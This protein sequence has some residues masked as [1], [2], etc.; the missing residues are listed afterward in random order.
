MEHNEK[1]PSNRSLKAR[2]A[3]RAAARKAVRVYFYPASFFFNVLKSQ[4]KAHWMRTYMIVAVASAVFIVLSIVSL[5]P[6]VDRTIN[7]YALFV[8]TAFLVSEYIGFLRMIHSETM[9][10]FDQASCTLRLTILRIAKS[11]RQIS[12]MV[13]ALNIIFLLVQFEVTLAPLQTGIFS[14]MTINA[15]YLTDIRIDHEKE[16]AAA[17]DGLSQLKSLPKFYQTFALRTILQHMKV[18]V[19]SQLKIAR[20]IDLSDVMKTLYLQYVL[21]DQPSDKI[22]DFTDKLKQSLSKKTGDIV[23]LLNKTFV[24]EDVVDEASPLYFELPW[25]RRFEWGQGLQWGFAI[26]DAIS[27]IYLLRSFGVFDALYKYFAHT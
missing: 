10:V 17:F 7:P 24:D 15:L 18:R 12:L 9:K 5:K 8:V 11:R 14:Y 26:L 22:R 20:E 1:K 27:A 21:R 19:E 3:V 23:G 16:M 2:E 25:E 13:F 4:L 6:V